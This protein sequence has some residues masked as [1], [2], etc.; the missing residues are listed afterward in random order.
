MIIITS[1][2]TVICYAIIS[3]NTTTNKYN[4]YYPY[5]YTLYICRVLYY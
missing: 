1:L 4:T 2:Y 5:Y 3:S